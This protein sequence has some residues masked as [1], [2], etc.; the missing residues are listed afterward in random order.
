MTVREL[1]ELL[2]H[3][4]NQEMTVRELRE[5]LY[6][7]NNQDDEM[8]AKSIADLINNVNLLSR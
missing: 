6:H 1:R 3:V 2:F 4:D 5:L 7:M 8:R